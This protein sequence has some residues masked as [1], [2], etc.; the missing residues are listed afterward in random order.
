MASAGERTSCSGNGVSVWNAPGAKVQDND[1]SF[2]RDGI[3]ADASKKNE[4]SRNV[5]S[6][7][8]FAV[9]YMYTNDS[10]IA[11]NVYNGNKS[12]FRDN[13]FGGCENG[14]HFTAGSEGS[15]MSGNAFVRNRN[16]VKYVGTRSPDCNGRALIRAPAALR[17]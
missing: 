4:F 14:V 5:F 3:F 1:I 11:D 13:L 17:P 6:N 10:V 2:G 12:R 9:H 16:Q 15:A 7:R 8:R